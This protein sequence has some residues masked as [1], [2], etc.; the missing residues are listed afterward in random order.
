MEFIEGESLLSK[1][2]RVG[3]LPV[4]QAFEIA[5]Q[6]CAGLREA[7]AQG[8]VHRD[9]KPANIMLDRSGTVK[10]MDFG[11]A[12]LIEGNGPMT[13]TIVGTP[14][15]MAPEQA[16]LKPVGPCTIPWAWAFR[17]PAQI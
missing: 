2:N 15:F 4:N 16:E 9:L 12:R 10:I 17:R 7:H 8:I 6:I 11:V 3:A 13:G 1:L 14:A 5:R